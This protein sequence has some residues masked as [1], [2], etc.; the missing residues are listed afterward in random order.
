MKR[1]RKLFFLLKQKVTASIPSFTNPTITQ[2]NTTITNDLAADGYSW[3]QA[4]PEHFDDAGN[5][6]A[7]AQRRNGGNT[8]HGFTWKNV[9]G[10]WQDAGFTEGFLSRAS[11]ALD[12]TNNVIH[13]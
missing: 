11:F 13:V 1:S 9:G 5:S 2:Q 4:H 10:N 6:I 8:V 3:S 12:K 7:L